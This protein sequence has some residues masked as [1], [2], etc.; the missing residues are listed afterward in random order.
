MNNKRKMKKKK[1][2]YKGK[3][4]FSSPGRKYRLQMIAAFHPVPTVIPKRH[5]TVV[6]GRINTHQTRSLPGTS[7]I[8]RHRGQT[9]DFCQPTV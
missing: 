4:S 9:R 6:S 2:E 5:P 3:G 8:V 7:L 1:R